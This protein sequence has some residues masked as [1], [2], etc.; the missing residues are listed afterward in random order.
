MSLRLLFLLVFAPFLAI[1]CETLSDFSSKAACQGDMWTEATFYL[2]RSRAEET[3]ES[4]AAWV[5]FVQDE[6]TPR[7]PDG[8]TVFEGQGAWGNPKTGET[9]YEASKVLV[10]LHPDTTE[11]RQKV[12][13]LAEAYRRTFDQQAVLTSQALTCA[14]FHTGPASND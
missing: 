10:I 1:G 14:T 2:G 3:A 13:L 8:F 12:V 5:Q 4:R 9:I 6:V 7:F 11:S